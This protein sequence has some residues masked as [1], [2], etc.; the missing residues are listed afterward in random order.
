M[1]VIRTVRNMRAELGVPPSKKAERLFIHASAGQAPI[2]STM[3]GAIAFLTRSE[4]VDISTVAEDIPLAAS[5]VAGENTILLPL[6]GLLDVQKEIDRLNK[7][8]TQL[9][10]ERDR[11][12]SQLSNEAFVAKAPAAVVEKLRNRRVEVDQQLT[13]LAA[14]IARWS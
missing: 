5:G 6:A 14:Q 3:Q 10:G 11:L 7:E 9:Q 8:Q 13:T 12:E 2:L 4:Q 1:E